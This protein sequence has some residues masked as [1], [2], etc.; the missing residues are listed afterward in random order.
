MKYCIFLLHPFMIIAEEIS[1]PTKYSSYD[2]PSIILNYLVF[3]LEAIIAAQSPLH[4]HFLHHVIPL[5]CN[6]TLQ[7]LHKGQPCRT[8]SG[9]AIRFML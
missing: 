9:S 8:S 2:I 3:A 4:C 5:E 6:R 1:S 7:L